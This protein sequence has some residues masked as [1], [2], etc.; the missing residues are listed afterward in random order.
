MFSFIILAF[1]MEK[2]STTPSH[3]TN[4]FGFEM[5]HEITWPWH[6]GDDGGVGYLRV[7]R[8][9]GGGRRGGDLEVPRDAYFDLKEKASGSHLLFHE[10]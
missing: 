9:F 4:A 10:R 2:K 6:L 8:I 7:C 3:I 5:P 1:P